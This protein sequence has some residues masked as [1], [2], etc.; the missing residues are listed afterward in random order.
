M[1]LKKEW[2]T[3]NFLTGVALVSATAWII[4]Y[5]RKRNKN[6]SKQIPGE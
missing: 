6:K 2:V 4:Q 3:T 5:S 1:L